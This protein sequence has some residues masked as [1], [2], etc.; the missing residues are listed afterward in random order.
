MFLKLEDPAVPSTK[1]K[2]PNLLVVQLVALSVNVLFWQFHDWAD[3]PLILLKY[4]ICII[5]ST[6]LLLSTLLC[7]LITWPFT[8]HH[9]EWT[10]SPKDILLQ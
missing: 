3:S 6:N 8:R 5:L 2:L 9:G 1:R 10:P 4:V 7:T